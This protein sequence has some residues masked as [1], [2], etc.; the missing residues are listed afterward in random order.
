LYFREK[1]AESSTYGG[2]GSSALLRRHPRIGV[3]GSLS[4]ARS[5]RK[6]KVD[7]SLKSSQIYKVDGDKRNEL[8]ILLC[9]D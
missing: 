3:F 4:C 5:S 9:K 2:S 7:D 8:T 1:A 6:L